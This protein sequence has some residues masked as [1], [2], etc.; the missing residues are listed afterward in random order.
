MFK[1]IVVGIIITIISISAFVVIDKNKTNSS[2]VIQQTSITE[3]ENQRKVNITGEVNHPGDYLIANDKT[4]GDL[5]YLAG[6]VTSKADPSA[7]N[8][9]VLI[10]TRSEFYIA[11]LGEIPSVCQIQEVEKININS[12]NEEELVSVGF[13][14]SQAS[15]IVK[16]RSEKGLFECLEDVQK[17]TG[18]GKATFNKVKGKITIS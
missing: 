14:S 11:A 13:T 3:E 18:V 6:G 5:I 8:E 7:Y 17:V 16:Y 9:S 4:L 15:N 2:T 1:T 10:S 12:A